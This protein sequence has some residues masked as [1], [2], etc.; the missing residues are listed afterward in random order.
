VTGFSKEGALAAELV[1]D[2]HHSP[3]LQELERLFL[4]HQGRVYRAAYRVTGSSSDAEDVLQT[5]F[6]RLVRSDAAPA[7]ANMASYL[8]RAAVNAALDVLRARRESVPLEEAE[9]RQEGEDAGPTPEEVRLGL[10]RALAA[11]SPRWAEIFV[12]RHFEGY[13]NEEI[14]RMLGMSRAVV[15]VTLYRAR[16]RL[17]KELGHKMRGRR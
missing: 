15:G 3:R 6:L 11:L 7:V 1:A 14:A 9:R 12:L 5:V 2:R 17:Q 16:H 4:E 13:G 10:R 8:Y